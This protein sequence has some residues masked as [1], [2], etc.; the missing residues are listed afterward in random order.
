MKNQVKIVN[1]ES[2]IF[3]FIVNNLKAYNLKN[4]L[5]VF[6]GHRPRLFLLKRLSE[7]IKK[8]FEPPRIFSFEDFIGYLVKESG[9]SYSIASD[10]DIIYWLYNLNL[11]NNEVYKKNKNHLSFFF[12]FVNRVIQD[13]ALILKNNCLD[14]IK[15]EKKNIIDKYKSNEIYKTINDYV[16]II[17]HLDKIL[18]EKGYILGA[19]LFR[20]VS[21][22]QKEKFHSIISKYDKVFLIDIIPL[23]KTE[24]TLINQLSSLPNVEFV[25]QNSTYL[26]EFSSLKDF[27]KPD[28]IPDNVSKNEINLYES[29]DIVGQIIGL[30]EMI[31]SK[32]PNLLFEKPDTLIMLPQTGTLEILNNLFFGEIQ[33]G[34]FNVS[35]GIPLSGLNMSR[36]FN[37]LF[38]TL[39]DRKTVFDKDGNIDSISNKRFT[40]LINH[41]YILALDGEEVK[42]KINDFLSKKVY[43]SIRMDELIDLVSSNK[44][45]KEFLVLLFGNLRDIKTIKDLSS[46]ICKI[47]QFIN[48]NQNQMLNYGYYHIESARIYKAF[49]EIYESHI[50]NISVA[51]GEWGSVFNGFVSSLKII[52]E[53]SPLKGLQVLGLY[54][55]RALRFDNVYILD[56]NDEILF[57][58]TFEDSYFPADLRLRL[59]FPQK[60]QYDNYILYFLDLLF[61]QGKDINIFYRGEDRLSRNRYILR[62][63]FEKAKE[64][65]EVQ[66]IPIYYNIDLTPDKPAV[67]KKDIKLIRKIINNGL[68]ATRL[69]T[70]LN[71][72]A[73]FYYSF[74]L[75]LEEGEEVSSEVENI[76]YGNIFHAAL[77]DYYTKY[78]GKKINMDIDISEFRKILRNKYN[79]A[80][81]KTGESI[82]FDYALI[83]VIAENFAEIWKMLHNEESREILYLEKE[84]IA[85]VKLNKD[86]LKLRGRIDRVDIVNEKKIEIIDYKFATKS[87]YIIKNEE[88]SFQ[89]SENETVEE[90]IYKR[91]NVLKSLN[92]IQLPFY[93]YLAKNCGDKSFKSKEEISSMFLFLKTLSKTKGNCYLQYSNSNVGNIIETLIK[94]IIDVNIPF[95]PVESKNCEWCKFYS[96]CYRGK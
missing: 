22:F 59:E 65:K 45:I 3:D 14:K 67:I 20:L 76:V 6:P 35:I 37:M 16:D 13:Y 34:G 61:Q 54:E 56:F 1:C 29:P 60:S 83:D 24:C 85:E 18:K 47:I 63:I 71:C 69:N 84:I 21:D 93:I 62:Y 73:Q 75:G 23:H 72:P 95:Y 27:I 50:A 82:L 9:Y 78:I 4:Y 28:R 68:S 53:G 80:V 64:K 51:I 86:K 8:P 81:Y 91:Q 10:V 88:I 30:K 70:Y 89:Y 55:S 32:N 57:D 77:Y 40:T 31:K 79:D 49:K 46:Y 36:F 12:S 74:V 41:E 25:F 43:E 26:K 38:D 44:K 33:E 5:I 58:Y 87:R 90:L 39:S 15:K 96:A 42:D 92:N 66:T 2:D 11:E 48:D 19:E 17:L 7:I 94:E 52:P